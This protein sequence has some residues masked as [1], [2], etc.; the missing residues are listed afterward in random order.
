MQSLFI[1][2]FTAV[3]FLISTHSLALKPLGSQ[4]HTFHPDAQEHADTVFKDFNFPIGRL[5]NWRI[6][7]IYKA[8]HTWQRDG[9]YYE[10]ESKPIPQYFSTMVKKMYAAGAEPVINVIQSTKLEE[11]ETAWFPMYDTRNTNA[12]YGIYKK[13]FDIGYSLSEMYAPGS[14]WNRLQGHGS[15]WGVKIYIALNEIDGPWYW[16][17]KPVNFINNNAIPVPKPDKLYPNPENI[18]ISLL[19]YYKINEAFAEGVKEGAKTVNRSNPPKVDVYLGPFANTKRWENRKYNNPTI[20]TAN[21]D[22]DIRSYKD[23][24]KVVKPLLKKKLITGFGMQT[25]FDTSLDF[26]DQK[27]TRLQE[28]YIAAEKIL[29]DGD[30]SLDKM[31]KLYIGEINSKRGK[32]PADD[33]YYDYAFTGALNALSIVDRKGNPVTEFGFWFNPLI[34]YEIGRAHV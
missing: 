1:C 27:Y 28:G 6:D 33:L 8:S 31:P 17:K 34:D 14:E 20:D 23:Y 29:L 24:L 12:K 16:Y 9:K 26:N 32:K 19:E 22:D 18:P 2:C 4:A 5:E 7:E 25:Y 11:D 30:D 13:W 21:P 10:D 3:L 15:N